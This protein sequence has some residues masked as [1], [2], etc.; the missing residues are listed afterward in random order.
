[1]IVIDTLGALR[2]EGMTATGYCDDHGARVL[3][4]DRLIEA[5]G[6]DW[7]YVGRRWPIKCAVCGGGLSVR[8]SP[9]GLP[10]QG[11]AH[12]AGALRAPD[13][14]PGRATP[15]RRP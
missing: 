5:K 4:L 7:R 8:L 12:G 2:R 11:A 6:A 13:G 1:M 14:S 9:G 10:T 3:D 15:S